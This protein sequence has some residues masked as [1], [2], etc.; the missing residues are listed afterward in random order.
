MRL[1][2]QKMR[3]QNVFKQ[4]MKNKNTLS[5]KINALKLFLRIKMGLLL[6]PSSFSHLLFPSGRSLLDRSLRRSR[7]T[8]RFSAT[9]DF[10]SKVRNSKQY[11]HMISATLFFLLRAFFYFELPP[12]S[13]D[14]SACDRS[15][16]H[17]SLI[18]ACSVIMKSNCTSHRR[19]KLEKRVSLFRKLLAGTEIKKNGCK[20]LFSSS[21]HAMLLDCFVIEIISVTITYELQAH[22][23]K[24][25]LKVLNLQTRRVI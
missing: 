10:A 21:T 1:N 24:N 11:V 14:I 19:W 22:C 12:S 6:L 25:I 20:R 18:G 13:H 5:V 4:R 2:Y 23:R 3:L 16:S 15:H 8:S 17:S 9:S 7:N